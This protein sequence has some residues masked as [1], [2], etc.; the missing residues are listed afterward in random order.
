M[1]SIGHLGGNWVTS[2]TISENFSLLSRHAWAHPQS[3]T[4]GKASYAAIDFESA[5]SA[6]GKT[7]APIQIGIA[8]ME[9]TALVPTGTL[10][11][12][13]KTDRAVT[14]VARKVH[15]ISDQDLAGAPSLAQLWPDIRKLME[16]RIIVAHSSATERRFLRL[17]P[18][19]GFGP[20]LDTLPLA[21]EIYPDLPSHRLGDLVDALGLH[22]EL[23]HACPG[24]QWHDALY[25]ATASL[26][27][28]R[29]LIKA[30]QLESA[31]LH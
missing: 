13:L 5:G 25:D 27:L 10:H 17:F 19:H 11:S 6:P 7:D 26:V 8:R 9:G 15:G 21:R 3:M 12:Y 31:P 24:L 20:W 18:T 22:S 30:G 14:W 28:L 16:N 1:A 2:S 23:A 29:H 4:F